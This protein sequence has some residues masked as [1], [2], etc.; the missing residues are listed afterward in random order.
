MSQS[1]GFPV[2]LAWWARVALMMAGASSLVMAVKRTRVRPGPSTAMTLWS[3]QPPRHWT[4]RVGMSRPS[5]RRAA[6]RSRAN[7]PVARRS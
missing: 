5:A 3:G 4:L 1:P 6:V 2:L 7:W